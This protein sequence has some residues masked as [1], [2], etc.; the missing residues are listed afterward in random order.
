[1]A[2]KTGAF[3]KTTAGPIEIPAASLPVRHDLL[4]DGRASIDH[5]AGVWFREPVRE[6]TVVAEQYDFS[7]S[8]L[9]LEDAAPLGEFDGGTEFD[10][11]D[12]MV[13]E[14]RR[15]EW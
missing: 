14:E 12:K 13:P 5:G 11:Y 7:I 2:L 3:F 4:R 6:M 10:T 15:R 1:M 8:L 9:L